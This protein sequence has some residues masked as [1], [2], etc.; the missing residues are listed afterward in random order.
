MPNIDLINCRDDENEEEI[1]SSPS[2]PQTSGLFKPEIG[3]YKQMPMDEG[4]KDEKYYHK[5]NQMFDCGTGYGPKP[6]YYC[7]CR[8]TIKN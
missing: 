6:M 4:E 8:R 5:E 7:I 3:N 2:F 1:Y